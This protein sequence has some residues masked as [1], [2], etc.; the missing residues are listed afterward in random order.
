MIFRRRHYPTV[1]LAL[2][3]A[4]FPNL[5]PPDYKIIR[6]PPAPM[7]GAMFSALALGDVL[8]GNRGVLICGTH[9]LIVTASPGP[10]NC[11]H[12][13]QLP[14]LSAPKSRA[15]QQIALGHPTFFCGKKA[16]GLMRYLWK[17]SSE[18]SVGPGRKSG[19]NPTIA[20]SRQRKLS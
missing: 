20:A 1:G 12:S 14:L 10:G 18:Q 8:T 9:T 3:Y 11:S 17:T 19:E 7:I 5:D 4:F 6:W 2:Q 16:G 15:L 13:R